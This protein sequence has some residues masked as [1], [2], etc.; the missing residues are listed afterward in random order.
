MV[1]SFL[2]IGRYRAKIKNPKVREV[3]IAMRLVREVATVKMVVDEVAIRD[4]IKTMPLYCGHV[5]P[6][7]VVVR[8]SVPVR[9]DGSVR[10]ILTTI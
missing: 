6:L 9:M 5:M 4:P 1:V 10:V 2:G 3:V 7:K 8:V